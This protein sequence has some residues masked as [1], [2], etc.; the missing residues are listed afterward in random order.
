M[1]YNLPGSSVHGISQQEYWSRLLFP[2]PGDLSNPAIESMSPA[3][4]ANSLSL[5]HQWSPN[6]EI[7]AYSFSVHLELGWA[8]LSQWC[9]FTWRTWIIRTRRMGP[10]DLLL[11]WLCHGRPGNNHTALCTRTMQE[12]RKSI[13]NPC[14]YYKPKTWTTEVTRK[15]HKS[16]W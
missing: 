9:K 3:L 4:Q 11:L 12:N 2:P 10:W 5:S 13:T 7:S 14:L 8:S 6:M 15:N 16:S 1:D